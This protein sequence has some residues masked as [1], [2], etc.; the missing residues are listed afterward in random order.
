[1]HEYVH[2]CIYVQA[3]MNN[4]WM[5]IPIRMKPV[6]ISPLLLYKFILHTYT[7][8]GRDVGVV[9]RVRFL[10]VCMHVDT[11]HHEWIESNLLSL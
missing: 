10:R 8:A 1:M 9:W 3:Y 6:L 2:T 4:V 11:R 7:H 5:L